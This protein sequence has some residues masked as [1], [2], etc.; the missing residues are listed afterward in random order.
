MTVDVRHTV[1]RLAL[2][3]LGAV[4]AALAWPWVHPRVPEVW[5]IAWH[6]A[7]SNS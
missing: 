1:V 7:F 6:I 2:V 5:A 4:A 3:S